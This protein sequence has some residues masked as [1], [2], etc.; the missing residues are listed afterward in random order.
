RCRKASENRRSWPPGSPT[1]AD[2]APRACWPWPPPAAGNAAAECKQPPEERAGGVLK[3]APGPDRG[4]LKFPLRKKGL[5]LLTDFGEGAQK[6]SEAIHQTSEQRPPPKPATGRNQAAGVWR[7]HFHSPSANFVQASS[8]PIPQ[9]EGIR[10][11]EWLIGY[12][13][14]IGAGLPPPGEI[15]GLHSSHGG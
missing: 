10:G 6:C 7:V 11:Q 4:L 12:T 14:G 9:Q 3:L 13:P 8:P 2:P 15:S 5:V 1:A